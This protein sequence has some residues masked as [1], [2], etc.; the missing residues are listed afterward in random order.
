MMEVRQRIGD[1]HGVAHGDDEHGGKTTQVTSVVGIFFSRA[2]QAQ[3]LTIP[4]PTFFFPTDNCDQ[5]S[6]RSAVRQP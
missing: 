2:C 3:C 1:T 4:L 6:Q 5:A